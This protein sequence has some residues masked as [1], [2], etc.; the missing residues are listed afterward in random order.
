MAYRQKQSGLFNKA[1]GTS[2]P[3]AKLEYLLEYKGRKVIVTDHVKDRARQRHGM[4]I[5]QMKVYFQHMIDGIDETNYAPTEYNEEVFVYV[6]A[7]KRGCV[8]AFRRDF[9]DQ[10]NRDLIMAV[11]TMYPYGTSKPAHPD[12]EVIYV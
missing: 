2:A 6:R 11:V 3:A 10:S 9:K 4:P 5:D 1:C 8:V 7:F 12:T